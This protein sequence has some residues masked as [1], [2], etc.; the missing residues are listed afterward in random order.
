M[1]YEV[2]A[3]ETYDKKTKDM[4]KSKLDTDTSLEELKKLVGLRYPY[5]LMHYCLTNLGETFHLV[6][7]L[8]TA[9]LGLQKLLAVVCPIWSKIQINERKSCFVCCTCFLFTLA[10]NVPKLFVISFSHGKEGDACLISEPQHT[11]QKYIL[12]YYPIMYSVILIIALVTMLIS[13]CYI[14]HIL[15]RRKRVRGHATASRT[16]KK[17][18]MLIVCVM[19]VFFLAEIPR[20]FVTSTLFGTYRS[21]LDMQNVVL[22]KPSTEAFQIYLACLDDILSLIRGESCFSEFNALSSHKRSII[23]NKL[24]TS[25]AELDKNIEHRSRNMVYVV[26]KDLFK[27]SY[28][29]YLKDDLLSLLIFVNKE[30]SKM[31]HQHISEYTEIEYCINQNNT[32]MAKVLQCKNQFRDKLTVSS[33]ALVS[34][35]YSEPMNYLLNIIWGL[36][37]IDMENFKLVIEILKLSM[38]IGSASNFLIYIV[39]SEKLRD[40][41]KKVFNCKKTFAKNHQKTRVDATEMQIRG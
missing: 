24:E 30:I 1:H 10:V 12:T 32:Y 28:Y 4:D 14:I 41:L 29:E 15:C 9:S 26:L 18:C 3:N 8:L 5:C 13:T 40:A 16:E 11:I 39:M 17:S 19:T 21:N 7:I 20:L 22:Q 2:I 25:W 38:I 37:D 23:L 31:F 34:S 35:P 27:Q 6:S 36:I 33:S